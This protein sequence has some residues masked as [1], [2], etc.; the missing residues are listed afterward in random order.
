LSQVC[1]DDASDLHIE[2]D[3]NQKRKKESKEWEEDLRREGGSK[4]GEGIGRGDCL[5]NKN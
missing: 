5:S 2:E 3:R 4:K 1:G